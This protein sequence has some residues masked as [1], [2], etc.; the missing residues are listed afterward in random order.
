MTFTK[1]FRS[2]IMFH[3]R[4]EADFEELTE[5]EKEYAAVINQRYLQVTLNEAAFFAC[6]IM[7]AISRAVAKKIFLVLGMQTMGNRIL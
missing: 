7:E 2:D 1:G 4:I 3:N 5:S 6:G